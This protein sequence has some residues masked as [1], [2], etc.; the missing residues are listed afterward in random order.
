[1]GLISALQIRSDD[2]LLGLQPPVLASTLHSTGTT[3][4]TTPFAPPTRS[5]LRGFFSA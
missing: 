5:V 2:L 3:V 1:V 4:A